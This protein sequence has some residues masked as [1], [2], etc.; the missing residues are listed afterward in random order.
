MK[1]TALLLDVTLSRVTLSG[2]PDPCVRNPGLDW[3]PACMGGTKRDRTESI[4]HEHMSDP[5][6]S[7]PPG[8]LDLDDLRSDTTHIN[9]Q[10]LSTAVVPIGQ[11]QG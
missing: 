7:R 1:A 11:L 3:D 8:T 10:L 9:L 4:V 5:G 6:G 2:D